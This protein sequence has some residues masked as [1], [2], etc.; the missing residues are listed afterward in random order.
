MSPLPEAK[1]FP[2]GD[3]L[4]HHLSAHNEGGGGG[5]SDSDSGVSH[6]SHASSAGGGGGGVSSGDSGASHDSHESSAGGGEA[7]APASEGPAGR[8]E[9]TGS[10]AGV[11]ADEVHR[12][13][14]ALDPHDPLAG[15]YSVRLRDTLTREAFITA[16][17][18][19]KDSAIAERA[20]S[21]ALREL[22]RFASAVPP[23][24]SPFDSS[25]EAQAERI[26]DLNGDRPQWTK[27]HSEFDATQLRGAAEQVPRQAHGQASAG[28]QMQSTDAAPSRA[29][30]GGLER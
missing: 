13:T 16:S 6:D 10:A 28:N 4:E 30:N 12:E 21:P 17:S 24:P 9:A 7:G 8:V 2:M 29:H 19:A 14:P 20:L 22:Y 27:G 25:R 11:H 5:A 26:A 23:E 1:P 15:L 18:L 3:E